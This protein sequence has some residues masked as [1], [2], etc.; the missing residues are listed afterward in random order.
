[1]FTLKSEHF[2]KCT[3]EMYA[4]FR[5]LDTPPVQFKQEL[6]TVLLSASVGARYMNMNNY[7]PTTTQVFIYLLTYLQYIQYIQVNSA[8]Y[9]PLNRKMSTGLSGGVIMNKFIRIKCK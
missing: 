8:F 6:K 7:F 2:Q 4:L 1:M 5:V 9:P 3:P